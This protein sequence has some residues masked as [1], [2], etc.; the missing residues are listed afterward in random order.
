MGVL[1]M[2][3]REAG[4]TRTPYA[5]DLVLGVR[6]VN[7]EDNE[8]QKAVFGGGVELGTAFTRDC[9]AY[10]NRD[11]GWVHT[12]GG[13]RRALENVKALGG[14]AI[15]ELV[16]E[17]R[18]TGRTTGFQCADDSVYFAELIVLAAGS[19]TSSNFAESILN[20]STLLLGKY[21]R[22]SH[23]RHSAHSS[24]Q[25]QRRKHPTDL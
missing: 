14:K 5:N 13:T 24:P 25:A 3:E 8:R 19:W 9:F 2:G 10:P 21:I 7:L 4:Y 18:E 1:I 12:E 20:H 15:K 6:V 17:N 23:L 22:S 11:G 16:K